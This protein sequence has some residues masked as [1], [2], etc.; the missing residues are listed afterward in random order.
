MARSDVPEPAVRE[1][2]RVVFDQWRV[3]LR[4]VTAGVRLESRF[5]VSTGEVPLHPGAV[6]Y[7]RSVYG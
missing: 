1:V 4:E 3:L 5:A 7:Y 6:A 2:L